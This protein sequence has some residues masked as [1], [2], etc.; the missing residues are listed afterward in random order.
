MHS[1]VSDEARIQFAELQSLIEVLPHVFH[2]GLFV[3]R[4]SL[5]I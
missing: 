2:A 5:M 3:N 4:N 1:F